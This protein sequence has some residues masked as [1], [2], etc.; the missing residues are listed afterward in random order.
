MHSSTSSSDS[1]QRGRRLDRFT[2]VLLATIVVMLVVTEVV[3]VTGFDRTS[4]VQ[5]RELAQRQAL[6]NVKDSAANS[7]SHIAVLGNSLLLDGVD[8]PL[9]SEK[10]APK[11]VPAP[12]FVLAT[13]Y[14]DWYF[15]LKRLFAQ[16]MRP[17]YV[18]LGLSPNQFASPRT[19]GDYSARYLFQAEDLWEVTRQTHMDATQTSEL[20]LSHFS[21][22]YGTRTVIRGFVL[23]RVL[24][25]V[26]ELLHNR[27]G[28]ARASTIEPSTLRR[29]A[30]ERLRALDELCKA[31]GS[32]FVLVIPP[33]YQEG[34]ETISEVGR[35]QGIPVLV[36]VAK[37]SLDSGY[38]QS[39]GFHLNEK[40]AR[41]FTAQLAARLLDK[42]PK[43]SN[44]NVEGM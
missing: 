14:Y 17:R 19:R 27:L 24:P 37:D 9:L 44:R 39:D 11:F 13:D 4:K 12:Y 25:I 40:G 23:S 35:N 34:A 8:V 42:W 32:Q 15:G 2:I 38:Y 28:N 33:T 31:N 10:L 43:E 7:S 3:C 20:L 21:E 36:P 5:R 22:Y 1:S 41:I 29:M 16:G 30:E 6:L 26:G 18:L